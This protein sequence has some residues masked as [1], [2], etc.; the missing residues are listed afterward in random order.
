MALN[1][2][3]MRGNWNLDQWNYQRNQRGNWNYREIEDTFNEELKLGFINKNSNWVSL[4]IKSPVEESGQDKSS[5]GRKGFD[6][7]FRQ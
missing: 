1:I 6:F 4:G 7:N 2:P 5:S 3:A